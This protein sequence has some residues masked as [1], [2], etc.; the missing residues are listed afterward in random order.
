MNRKQ[1]WFLIALITFIIFLIIDLVFKTALWKVGVKIFAGTCLLYG[2]GGI[3][4]IIYD[5][6]GD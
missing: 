6:L 3:L 4:Y 2:V 1:E 5:I